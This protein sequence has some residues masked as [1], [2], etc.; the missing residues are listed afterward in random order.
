M[1]RFAVVIP[2]NRP[3]RFYGWWAAWLRLLERHDVGVFVCEDLD[4]PTIGEAPRRTVLRR[5]D[6]PWWVPRSTDMCRSWAMVH[7]YRSGAEFIVSLDDDV[8]PIGDVF[9]A[10]ES[11]F[12]RGAVVS[13]YFDVGAL[14][15]FP[16][17]MRGFPYGH[18]D[19]RTVGLQVGGWSGVLDFDART[20]LEVGT[21]EDE[22]AG[23]VVPVPKGSAVTVCAMNMAFRREFTPLMWQLPLLDGRYN[24]WGDI[25][26]G[27]LA[28]RALDEQNVAVVVNG[29]AQVRHERASNPHANL[30]REAPGV[31]INEGLWEK[32]GGVI[33]FTT[34][35]AD[36]GDVEY[37]A[38]CLNAYDAW[39]AEFD[40]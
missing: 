14:T 2:T 13:E 15:T 10:Y 27:L 37:A 1:S 33:S 30:E 29:Q 24:R 7:A 39:L 16:G 6:W 34:H 31:P 12:D 25:W 35:L 21:R 36:C 23:L 11:V 40:D 17:Q 3:D 5:P 26:A 20:Q 22:F 9:A 18:R 28:K 8:E 19:R 4:E 32:L 38:H